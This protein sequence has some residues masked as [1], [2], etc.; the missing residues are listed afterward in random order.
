M[1][2]RRGT[3]VAV[4]ALTVA[5][6]ALAWLDFH[7]LQS[8]VDISPVAPPAGKAEA[9]AQHGPQPATALDKKTAEQF[10]ETVNRPLF[11]PSRRPV[12]RAEPPA[13]APKVEPAKL[14]LVGVM[15]VDDGPPRALIR[16][17]DEPSGRWIAE[18]GAYHGWTLTKVNEGSVIVEAGGRTQELMLFVP[19]PP[20]KVPPQPPPAPPAT[21]QPADPKVEAQSRQQ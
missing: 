6:G 19:P 1:G 4:A 7:L 13:R 9:H 10:Q 18:G 8:P 11:N 15:K 16:F 12:Q 17:A 3:T 2:S 14:R 5:A 20:Q 21:Q